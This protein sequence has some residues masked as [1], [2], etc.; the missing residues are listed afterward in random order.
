MSKTVMSIIGA[1]VTACFLGAGGWIFK[2]TAEMP[3]KYVLKADM[4]TFIERN[5]KE[6]D[7]IAKKLDKIIEHLL[8]EN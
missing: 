6:H 4:Q 5:D 8:E 7:E 2:A 3:E 1:V